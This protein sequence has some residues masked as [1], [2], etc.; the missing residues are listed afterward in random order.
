MVWGA[1]SLDALVCLDSS[2]WLTTLS[3]NQCHMDSSHMDWPVPSPYPDS[4]F[5]CLVDHG[6][7]VLARALFTRLHV[8]KSQ[9]ITGPRRKSK[10]GKSAAEPVGTL[11]ATVLVTLVIVAIV[12]AIR[13]IGRTHHPPTLEQEQS[14][15]PKN[16]W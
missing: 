15:A 11:Y 2:F 8:E 3:V 10:S 13:W 7:L 1:Y 6:L 4:W 5:G 16:A 14:H 9:T 12:L